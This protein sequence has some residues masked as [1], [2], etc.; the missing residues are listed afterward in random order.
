M[1]TIAEERNRYGRSS[2]ASATSPPLRKAKHNGTSE[3][4][5]YIQEPNARQHNT[6]SFSTTTQQAACRRLMRGV[7]RGIAPRPSGLAKR[8]VELVASAEE[9]VGRYSERF[10]PYNADALIRE[11]KGQA[12][13]PG[14]ENGGGV[15][16]VSGVIGDGVGN[17]RGRPLTWDEME[18]WEQRNACATDGQWG[19]YA[20]A[21]RATT[22]VSA[23]GGTH[24]TAPVDPRTRGSS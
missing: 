9:D 10:T 18:P 8:K 23:D 21:S 1:H 6:R 22:V 19:G 12:R 24:E 11:Q 5:G 20:E 4:K 16:G 15:D 7:G 14:R 3:S 17:R 13:V 2:T